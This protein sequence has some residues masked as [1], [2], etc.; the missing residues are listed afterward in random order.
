MP[1]ADPQHALPEYD[2]MYVGRRFEILRKVRGATPAEWSR[3]IGYNCTPQKIWNYE[4]G[5]DQVPVPYAARV[6]ILTGASFD[7]LYRG[8]YTGVSKSLRRKIEVVEAGE[9]VLSD[10]QRR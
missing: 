9:A 3:A 10:R 6:C 7:Y 4:R 1:D 8:M 2:K 5:Q